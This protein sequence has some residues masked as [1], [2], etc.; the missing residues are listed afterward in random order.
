M[1]LRR[2]ADG[3][4]VSSNASAQ[5][6][7]SIVVI[8]I[9]LTVIFFLSAFLHLLI[10]WLARN[11]ALNRRAARTGARSNNRIIALTAFQGQL[12]QLFSMQDAGLES[13]MIEEL[14]VFSYK[15]AMGG[16]KEGADCAICLCEFV[17]DDQLRLLPLCGHAF[18]TECIDTWLF[19]HSTCPLCRTLLL[20]E[21]WVPG[22]LPLLSSEISTTGEAD[23]QHIPVAVGGFTGSSR[24]S[25][26]GHI[27]ATVAANAVAGDRN[28]SELSRFNPLFSPRSHV[29]PALSINERA[30]SEA[31]APAWGS[32]L[33]EN[34]AN[35]GTSS[36]NAKLFTSGSSANY[37]AV[38]MDSGRLS[39]TSLGNQTDVQSEACTDF[40]AA[41]A[42]G[43]G[44]KISLHLGKCR[45]VQEQAGRSSL[46]N[47]K[48][49]ANPIRRSYSKG[50]YEYVIDSSSNLE[51]IIPPLNSQSKRLHDLLNLSNRKTGSSV[52]ESTSN[53]VHGPRQSVSKILSPSWATASFRKFHVCDGEDVDVPGSSSA[54][55]MNAPLNMSLPSDKLAGIEQW[56]V[57]ITPDLPE[58]SAATS[59][60][61]NVGSSEASLSPEIVNASSL[62]EVMISHNAALAELETSMRAVSFRLPT[63]ASNDAL[64]ARLKAS[65]SRRALSASEAFS[66]WEPR[67]TE[68]LDPEAND[69]HRLV[70][71]D[72]AG[73]YRSSSFAKRTADWLVGWQ[74]RLVHPG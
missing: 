62:A 55:A 70:F 35:E 67:F 44:R 51:V 4:P 72:N 8:I 23:L 24:R 5:V 22:M 49:T 9:V 65:A 41:S 39:Y 63:P 11:P 56:P 58:S 7:P 37:M 54:E 13:A 57:V 30:S 12:Q 73:A 36:A 33:N 32:G 10:R 20:P 3:P 15:A 25:S 34:R 26:L 48:A 42:Y 69:D 19:S 16:L 31:S 64:S 28:Q 6:S 53:A 61:A 27:S 46:S 52:V 71:N 29:D 43:S 50:S 18:H 38:L 45:M 17:G 59:I 60:R 1:N 47:S 2:L 40:D 21:C 14:P 66:H 68:H 74:R